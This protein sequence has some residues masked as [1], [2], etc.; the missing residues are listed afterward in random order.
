M[1]R[2]FSTE[3]AALLKRGRIIGGSKAF[4]APVVNDFEDLAI[5]GHAHAIEA[6]GWTR[7]MLKGSTDWLALFSFKVY[8]VLPHITIF[9]VKG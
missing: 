4:G 9:R 6:Q 2:K 3:H 7:R 8:C 1:R 5:A